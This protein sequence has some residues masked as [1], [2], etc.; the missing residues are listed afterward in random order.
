MG[1]TREDFA[2]DEP[3]TVIFDEEMS[4]AWEVYAAMA[5]QWRVSPS[6]MPYGLD[7]NVLPMMFKIYKIEDEELCLGDVRILEGAALIE[8]SKKS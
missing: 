1:F 2:D 5:T 6:G 4:Q 3:E 8:M 7:Y